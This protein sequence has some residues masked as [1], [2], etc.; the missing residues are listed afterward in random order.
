MPLGHDPLY[1]D[2]VL[3]T[4]QDFVATIRPAAGESIPT[5]TTVELVIRNTQD[6][7]TVATWP[8]AVSTAEATWSVPSTI[9]DAITAP[10]LIYRVYAHFT[11]GT[12]FVWVRGAVIRKH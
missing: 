9:T 5:G 12:D 7:T 4:G 2:M 8:A 3:L 1:D 10:S 6:T 11:D